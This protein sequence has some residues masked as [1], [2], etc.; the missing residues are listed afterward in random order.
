MA[1]FAHV[2]N[3]MLNALAF[4][5]SIMLSLHSGSLGERSDMRRDMLSGDHQGYYDVILTT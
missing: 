5:I 2:H 3:D 1:A 4:R